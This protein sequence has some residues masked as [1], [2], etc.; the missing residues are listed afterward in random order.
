MT[1][2]RR[3]TIRR[4][5]MALATAVITTAGVVAYVSAAPAPP[6]AATSTQTAPA[7]QTLHGS[8]GVAAAANYEECLTNYNTECVANAGSQI[9]INVVSG[10]G[11]IAIV[12]VV[13]KFIGWYS[14]KGT[15]R[16][17]WSGYYE[18]GGTSNGGAANTN[19]CLASTEVGSE[20]TWQPCG[21]NGTVWIEEPDNNGGNYNFNRYMVNNLGCVINDPGYDSTGQCGVMTVY[22]LQNG[23]PLF[24]ALPIP[25]GGSEL[26]DWN[27]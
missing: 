18:D 12:Y 17:L 14:Q 21:A 7:S 15:H 25:P 24:L 6:A 8:A 27:P 11:T 22:S 5:C 16:K 4:R 1:I 19:L 23:S 26:Q 20:I 10:L 2:F 9:A 3:A 13:K